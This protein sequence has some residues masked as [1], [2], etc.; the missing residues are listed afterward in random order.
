MRS[1]IHQVPR[2]VMRASLECY[3]NAETTQNPW[4]GEDF[5]EIVILRLGLKKEKANTIEY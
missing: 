3:G 1:S 5:R 2:A 4:S